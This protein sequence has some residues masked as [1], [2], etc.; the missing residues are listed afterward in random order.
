MY[1]GV[2]GEKHVHCVIRFDFQARALTVLDSEKGS[3]SSHR[4]SSF[5]KVRME[6]SKLEVTLQTKETSLLWECY[7]EFDFDAIERLCHKIISM[8]G[9]LAAF[10]KERKPQLCFVQGQGWLKKNMKHESEIRFILVERMAIIHPPGLESQPQY[11]FPLWK[12]PCFTVGKNG[13]R[14]DTKKK[15]VDVFF[16]SEEIR[17][18]YFNVIGIAAQKTPSDS[19]PLREKLEMLVRLANTPFQ[20]PKKSHRDFAERLWEATIAKRHE[21]EKMPEST[22]SERW[23]ELGLS[24]TSLALDLKVCNMLGLVMIVYFAE[25]YNADFME[26]VD[27]Q[28]EAPEG[29]KYAVF[30]NVARISFMLFSLLNLGKKQTTWYPSFVTYPM[31]NYDPEAFELLV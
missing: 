4:F 6:K 25:N 27:A 31:W 23:K 9:D 11:L 14:F 1:F 19:V 24:T 30:P 29:E 28:R 20:A 3:H 26:I 7:N 18:H 21:G 22:E 5:E 10:W 2:M 8:A 15:S 17:D 12:R 16:E 13:V